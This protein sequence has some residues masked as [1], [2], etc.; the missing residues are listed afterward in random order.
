MRVSA[1]RSACAEGCAREDA[2]AEVNRARGA[3]SAQ[4][5]GEERVSLRG[6]SMSEHKAHG[7]GRAE[8]DEPVSSVTPRRACIRKFCATNTRPHA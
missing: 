7:R 8:A 3:L 6:E 2:I 4:V 1:T 5:D